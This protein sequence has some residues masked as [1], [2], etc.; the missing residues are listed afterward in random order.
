MRPEFYEPEDLTDQ[1][2]SD[3]LSLAGAAVPEA[4]ITRWSDMEK[5]M[6]YDWAM[7]EHLAASDNAVRRRVKPY[8]VTLCQWQQEAT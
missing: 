8:L 6:A 1:V 4:N 7:R 3:A 5:V 2:V